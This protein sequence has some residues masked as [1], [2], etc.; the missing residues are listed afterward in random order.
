[1]EI[2]VA[3]KYQ[4]LKKI[5]KGTFGDVFSAKDLESRRK[6]AIKLQK[7]SYFKSSFEKEIEILKRLKGI[8]G[9]PQLKSS[10][11][12]DSR[13][14][15]VTDLCEESLQ[16][17][18]DSLDNN[19]TIS[20]VSMIGLQTLKRLE[21]MHK[22][23][24]LHLDLKPHNFLMKK[25]TIK[26]ID[27]GTSRSYYEKNDHILFQNKKNFVGNFL[28][29]SKNAHFLHSLSR[30]DDLESWCYMISYL[31]LGYLPWYRGCG[32]PVDEK[33]FGF[34]KCS[35]S[36]EQLFKNFD[37]MKQV[38]SYVCSLKFEENPDYR[39]IRMKLKDLAKRSEDKIFRI[40][41]KD[42]KSR[43]CGRD[44]AIQGEEPATVEDK[45]LPKFENRA[46]FRSG[47]KTIAFE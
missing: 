21:K 3:N 7:S 1:M 22:L 4:L 5:G 17:R 29:C 2:T 31:A 26:L 40:F 9:F 20:E 32:S 41:R 37:Q 33:I 11:E 36:P 25:K 23:K 16:S 43:R 46:G 30:R 35:V 47:S 19:L 10:G 8:H 38:F 14:F 6:V 45:N 28:Y 12:H 13:L 42:E 15:I 18:F 34:F 24:L 44:L 39:F 27:F